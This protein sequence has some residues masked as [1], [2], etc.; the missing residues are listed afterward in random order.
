MALFTIRLGRVVVKV[1]MDNVTKYD[2]S[3]K[4]FLRA[5][6]QFQEPAMSFFGVP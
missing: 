3:F 4:A 5:C 6:M 1:I 2:G